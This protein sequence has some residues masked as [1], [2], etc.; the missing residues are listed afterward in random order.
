MI[1]CP[2]CSQPAFSYMKKIFIGP[3]SHTKCQSCGTELSV[4]WTAFIAWLFACAVVFLLPLFLGMGVAA[5]VAL[6]VACFALY[7]F[8]HQKC[9]PL[10]AKKAT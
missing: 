3:L 7:I 5:R 10:V 2:V 4:S 1:C 6:F 9:V 8:F